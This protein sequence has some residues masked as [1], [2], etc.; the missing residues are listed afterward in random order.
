MI[1]IRMV[2]PGAGGHQKERKELARNLK[3]K[4]VGRMDCM[5]QK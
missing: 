4:V 1:W 3:G 5:K 2:Q